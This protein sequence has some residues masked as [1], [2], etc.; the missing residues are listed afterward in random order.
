MNSARSLDDRYI[1]FSQR[2]DS[3]FAQYPAI[4]P[5]R[6]FIFR[7]L[8]IRQ[9]GCSWVDHARHWAGP[10]RPRRRRRTNP[11]PCDVLIWVESTRD[12]IVDALVP[13]HEALLRRGVRALL[14]SSNGPPELPSPHI[15][16]SATRA[17][18][19]RWARNAWDAL[20]DTEPALQD[21]NL[22]RPFAYACA[23]LQGVFNEL[24]RILGIARPRVVL[25][26]STQLPGGAALMVSARKQDRYS[27]L[28][29]HGILQPFYAPLLADEMLTWGPSSTEL[30][31]S[32]GVSRDSLFSLGSPRHDKLGMTENGAARSR[33]LAATDLPDRPTLVFFSNGNDLLRNGDAPRQCAEWLEGAAARHAGRLNV[34]VRPHPNEDG[35]L[36]RDRR[37]LRISA[38]T[39]PLAMVLAGCD[40]V[41]SLC[42]TVLYDALLFGK[43]VWQFQADAWPDLAHNWKADLAS[44]IASAQDLDDAIGRLLDGQS[45]PRRDPQ[46]IDR[47]FAN[48]GHATSAIADHV[49]E[50]LETGHS[51][52]S[53]GEP[54][55]APGMSG[56][57]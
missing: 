31:A 29:Q 38:Q 50:F 49:I 12:V 52:P 5:L 14:V 35:S 15:F 6:Y 54:A 55:H 39:L 40:A 13:V 48:H 26:A 11:D 27:I 32:L 51:T 25:A 17:L 28:Q 45:S 34:L 44:R 41:A 24:D 21:G 1:E 16:T 42:S 8:A 56:E 53:A 33:L 43:P 7:Q 19:P 47:V 36:Y 23:R 3:V 2:T 9:R 46:K 4:E 10:F 22:W 20:C 37:H 18:S 57:S 30:L